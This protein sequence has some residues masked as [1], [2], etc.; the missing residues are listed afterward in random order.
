MPSIHNLPV[1]ERSDMIARLKRVEGQTKGIQK[2]ID[3]GRD[4]LEVMNQVAA[5]K[6]AVNAL[7]GEMLG[8]FALH[9]L[10]HPM[11]FASPEQAIEEAVR[12]LVRSGR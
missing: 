10:R 4:C 6:A 1:E 9:C 12:A 3:E 5:V 7:S 2:M 11:E 8:T